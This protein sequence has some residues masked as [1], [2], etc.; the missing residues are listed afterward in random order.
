M[1][2]FAPADTLH[3]IIVGPDEDLTFVVVY[4]PPGPE[5]KLKKFGE[6]AFD[7]P[8]VGADSITLGGKNG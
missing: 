2:V 7:S 1:A 3:Q 8:E 4:A 6:H 5:Q